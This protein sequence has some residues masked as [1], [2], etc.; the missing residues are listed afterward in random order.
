MLSTV[1]LVGVL[2]LIDQKG[3]KNVRLKFVTCFAIISLQSSLRNNRQHRFVLWEILAID[4]QNEASEVVLYG[5]IINL[6]KFF[7]KIL[8]TFDMFSCFYPNP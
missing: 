7:M 6:N 8:S 4:Q 1:F 2:I 5:I 3:L